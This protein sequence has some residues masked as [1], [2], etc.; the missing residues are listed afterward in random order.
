MLY[1]YLGIIVL[2]IITGLWC[3]YR[4]NKYLKYINKTNNNQIKYEE[5]IEESNTKILMVIPCLREQD[6]INDTLEHFLKITEEFENVKILIVT[7]QKEEYEK[8]KSLYLE[9]ELVRDIKNSEK[10]DKVVHKY[11]KLL[12]TKEIKS[13]YKVKR[14]KDIRNKVREMVLKSKTTQQVVKD[15]IKKNKLQDKIYHMH[16]PKENGIMADQL[17]YV[18]DNFKFEDEKNTYFS[19]YNADSIPDENTLNEVLQ[20]IKKKNNPKVIQQYAVPISNWNELSGLMKGFAIY[21][22][23]FELRYGLINA[24]LYNEWL[25]TYV[26]GHGMYFRVDELEKIG[27]FETKYWCEDIYMSLLLRNKDINIYPVQ[28]LEKMQS[29]QYLSILIR[30]NAVWFRTSFKCFRIFKDIYKQNKKINISIIGWMIQRLRMNFNWIFEPV[31]L[32]IPFVISI[33][34]NSIPMFLISL[35]AYFCK[36]IL[37]YGGTI[38]LIEKLSD[39]K[40]KNKTKVMFLTASALSISNLGP[41]YSLI[42]RKKEK[43]KTIR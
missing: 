2:E 23:N 29:P 37:E 36:L 25:Y 9:S 34:M 26:L 27:G 42:R 21:Q 38:K 15:F 40:F 35:L 43:Y 18:L 16:Y 3:F 1:L 39:F 30:Q 14:M 7:T 33:I 12:S 22:S 17:N 5:N 41:L 13:L 8:K 32:L 19:V 28:S 10:I 31:I 6:I 4:K 24:S 11:N 20:V